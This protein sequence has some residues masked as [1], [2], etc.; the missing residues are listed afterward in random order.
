MNKR[1]FLK[2]VFRMSISICFITFMALFLSQNTGYLEHQ[3]RRQVELTEKQIKKFERD[4]ALGKNIDMKDY[5]ETYDY[6][7]QNKL[8]K[9]GLRISNFTG[10]GVRRIVEKS[11]KVLSKLAE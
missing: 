1:K 5:L 11:F 8:S 3:N 10:N 9:V 2:K 4:V 7:Y 6:D